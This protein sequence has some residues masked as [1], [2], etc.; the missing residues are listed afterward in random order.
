MD[1][2]KKMWR[3]D[4]GH[5]YKLTNNS[6]N[7]SDSFSPFKFANNCSLGEELHYKGTLIRFP[8][9]KEPSGLSDKLYTIPKLKELL[10]ALNDDAAILLL[11]L[12]YVERIEVFTIDAN[13]LVTKIFSVE[14]DK[15]SECQRRQLKLAFL[16]EVG[17][18]HS[19][20]SSPLPH[21]QYE[22]TITVHDVQVGTHCECQWII[23]HWVG[24][25]DKDVIKASSKVS[26]LPWIGLAVPLTLQCS[27]R[28]FCFLPLPD[29]KEVNPP[30]PLC[31]HGTFGLNKDRRHLK[32]IT[33][34][35]KNDDGAL[36]NK[37]LFSD[38]LPSCYAEC[39]NLLKEKCN[40]EI[41]YSFWPCVSVV[42]TTNWNIILHPLL[43]LLLQGQYFWSENGRWVGLDSSVCVVPQ[44][45]S[46]QFPKVVIDVLIK[47]GKTVVVLP[48][49]VWDAVK[50][51]NKSSYPFATITPSA[52][53]QTIRSISQSYSNL[54]KAEKFQLLH[55]CL[56]DKD[57][58]NLNGI[59]LLPTVVNTFIA[60]GTDQSAVKMYVCDK[61]FL[62]TKLLANNSSTLVNVEGEDVRLHDK[63]IEVANS[64][65]TQLHILKPE[66]VA[67][68]LKQTSPFQN[69]WCCYGSAGGF[70]NENWLKTFWSW[71]SADSLSFFV[72][73]PLI[74]VC[75]GKDDNGFKVVELNYQENTQ[76]F[77]C[78]QSASLFFC[79]LVTAGEKLGCHV[80]SSEE[81]AF[82]DCSKL[83][84]YVPQLSQS[85]LLNV[86]HANLENIFFSQEEATALRQFLFYH[87]INFSL[88]VGQRLVALKLNIFTIVQSN[89][90]TSLKNATNVL[91][92]N[93]S[94]VIVVLEPESIRKYL[95]FLPPIITCERNITE[96]LQPMLPETCWFPTKLQLIINVIF[97]AI[98]NKQLNKAGI[99]KV[100]SMLLEPNEYYSLVITSDGDLLFNKLKLLKYLPTSD[101]DNDNLFSPC[102]VYD[103]TDHVVKELFEGQNVFP[104]APF[105]SAHFPILKQLG[106]KDCNT[107]SSSD[108][109]RVTDIICCETDT[110]A[111]VKRANT[112]L[113]FLSSPTGN[114]LLNEY[115]NNVPLDQTLR[116][117]Q[118]LPVITTPPKGY[119]KCLSWKGSS[120][121]QFVF[122]QSLHASSSPEEHKKLPNLIGSQMKIL[123]YEGTLSVKLI[124]SLNIPQ[125]VPV[126][127]MILQLLDLIDHNTHI[128]NN[129]LKENVKQLYSYLQHAAQQNQ[130]SQYWLLLSQSEVVQ[131]SDNKFVLPSVVAC[132]FDQQSE[133]VGTLEPY[134]YILP[135]HLQQ[136]R[137]LFQYIGV[138]EQITVSDVLSVLETISSLPNDDNNYDEQ[139]S[140]ITKVLKWVCYSFTS[141]EIQ[142]LRGAIFVPVK[143]GDNQLILKPADQVACLDEDLQWL[144]DNK[145]AL[146][147]IMQDYFLVHPS[148]SYNMCC[149]L[150][151]KPLNTMIANSEEF[152]FEQAG[153]SEPL[154]TRLNRI[155]R[156]YKDTSVIQELLQ[157]AD[158]AGA[159]EVA[160]FYDTR[161]HDSSHLF[162]PGM[163]NSYGP[164]LLFYNNAE[165]SE[166]DFEN[167][168][169]IAGET[170]MNKP[171]KIGKFGVGF[172][173]VYHITDVPSFVS[174]ENFVVF[175]PTLQCLSKE[176]KS[177]SNPRIKI[178]FNKHFLL[179]KSK[180]LNPYAGI[181]GFNPCKNFEGT[182]FRFP[183]RSTSSEIS[184]NT[185]TESKV[186]SIIG[187]MK[188]YSSKLLM[189]LHNVKKISFYLATDDSITKNFEVTI[190]KQ[191]L[192]NN[193]SLLTI[194]TELAPNKGKGEN[195][196]W[197]VTTDTKSLQ[198]S[199]REKCHGTSSV[200]IKLLPSITP[201]QYH[202][203]DITGECFCFL[204]LNI[205]T[206]LPVHVSSNFAVTTNRRGIWKADNAVTAT[207]ESNW[208]KMLMETVVAEAY[209]KLLF[210]LQRMQQVGYIVDYNFHSLWPIGLREINPWEILVNKI[211]TAILSNQYSLF[212]SEITTQ[213]YKLHQCNFLSNKILAVGVGSNDTILQSSLYHVATV[214]HLPVVNLPNSLWSKFCVYPN[215]LSQVINEGK[216]IRH[217][218]RDQ[219]L[220][221][222]SAE[223]KTE[224]VTAS[225]ITYAKNTHDN[226]L[227]ELLKNTKCIPCSPDGKIFKKPL[228]LLDPTSRMGK[229][230]L[231]EDGMFPDLKFLQQNNILI[232]LLAKIGL[233]Q[234]LCW[235]IVIDRA[236]CVQSWYDTNSSEALGR[237]LVLI[238][239]IEENSK[240]KFLSHRITNELQSIPFLP[241]MQKPQHYPISWKGDS[242]VGHLLPGPKLT[243]V[244]EGYLS[245]NAVH[246]CGS[247]V[248]IL[249]TQF[250]SS[251]YHRR[252][253]NYKVQNILGIKSDIG[254]ID[255][256]NHFS[257]LL[258]WFQA[259][260]DDGI[261]EEVLKNVSTIVMSV[262]QYINS[263]LSFPDHE[264]RKHLIVLKDK[265]CIW[266]TDKFLIPSCVAINWK[267]DGPYLYKLPDGL[268]RFR[269]LVNYL[270]I[271]ANFATETYLNT[272]NKMKNDYK[273]GSLP[274]DCQTVIR[275][276][277]PQLQYA[278]VNANQHLSLPDEEFVLRS[279]ENLKYNDAP[280]CDPDEEYVYCH[281]C[282]ERTTAIRLGVEPMRSALLQDHE[283]DVEGEEFGQ[284]EDLT[285]RL[286]N[287]L[288]DYP[289][290]I[291]FLK[292]ILQNADD[293][294]A[295][296]LYITLDKRKHNHQKVI[297]EE[298]KELHGPALL[299]W[300]DS[301]F[302]K[303]DFLGIQKLG[304]GSKSIDASTVGQYGIGFNVV[305][306]FTDCPSFITAGKLCILDPYHY[307][308]A[309]DKRKRPGKIL[310]NL[311][312]LWQKFPDMKS[313]YLLNDLGDTPKE[314]KTKGSLFRLP[315]RQNIKHHMISKE[316]ILVKTLEKELKE[317]M[318]QVSEA[319]L[320]LHHISDVKFFIIDDN[321]STNDF[322]W[323]EATLFHHVQSTKGEQRVIKQ[324]QNGNAKLVSYPMTLNTKDHHVT[325]WIVQLGKGNVEDE[326][327]DWNS[328][329]PPNVACNPHHGIAAPV[330]T[331][332]FMGKS[333]CY[334][335]LPGMTRLPV[336]VHGH[337]I[338]HSD[339][340]GLWVSS[341]TKNT[342]SYGFFSMHTALPDLKALWNDFMIKAVGVSYAYLLLDIA[343]RMQSPISRSTLLKS[344]YN[345]YPLLTFLTT[346]PWSYLIKY[347][348]LTLSRLNAPILAKLTKCSSSKIE[349]SK[350]PKVDSDTEWFTVTWYKLLMPNSRNECYFND[351]NLPVV[352]VLISIGMN[353]VDTPMF[354]YKEFKKAD[355]KIQL[356]VVSRESVVNY[357]IQFCSQILN[358]NMLPCAISSTQFIDIK[359]ISVLLQYLMQYCTFSKE[360]ISDKRFVSLGLIVTV[361][362]NLHSLSDGKGIVS[363]NSWRSFPN[364]KQCFIHNDLRLCYP[365]QSPYL[366]TSNLKNSDHFRCI[367]SIIHDNYSFLSDEIDSTLIRNVLDCLA[368]DPVFSV[369]CNEILSLFALLPA[370]NNQF[371]STRSDILPLTRTSGTSYY[372]LGKVT[373]LMI[374]LNVPLLQHEVVG[375]IL[376]K[377]KLQLPSVNNPQ[378]ILKS[379]YLIRKE[380][381]NFVQ[382]T[383]QEL[384]VLFTVFKQIPYSN[385]DNQRYI[386]HLPVFTTVSSELVMLASAKMVW[387][388][389][390]KE[391]CTAGIDQWISYVPRN[392]LFLSPNAPWACIRH[393]AKSLQMC[394]INRYDVYCN[395][396]FPNFHSLEP[397]VQM[398]HLEFVKEEVYPNCKHVLMYGYLHTSNIQHKV[399]S[400]VSVLKDLRCIPDDC[401]HLRAIRNFYDHDNHMFKLFCSESSFL[402]T[403]FRAQDWHEFFEYFGLRMMPAVEEFVSYCKGLPR[404]GSVATIKNASLVLLRALLCSPTIGD[405][406]YKALKSNECTR[407]ISNIPIAVIEEVEDL[408]CIKAQRMGEQIVNDGQ[409]IMHL[410]KL[411]GST[412]V[413]NKHLL[414]TIR[415]L[416]NLPLDSD[417]QRLQD[418]GV[419]QSPS[420]EDVIANL[421][422]LSSTVFA[423]DS[424]FDKHD[425]GPM[426]DKSGLLPEVVVTMLK[427]IQTKLNKQQQ[428]P[429]AVCKKYDLTNTKFLPVKL[430]ATDSKNYVLVKP[431][432]VLY[433]KPTWQPYLKPVIDS[434][435][436]VQLYPYLHPLI[437]E[438]HEVINFLSYTGVRVSL[439]FSH[440]QFVLQMVQEKC[441]NSVVDENIRRVIVKATDEL[442]KLLQQCEKRS[443]AAQY[444]KPLYLLSQD[445]KLVECS[446][447]IVY[448]I[449]GHQQFP[450]PAGYAY[451]NPLRNDYQ[452]RS[453]LLSELLPK[454]LGLKSLKS[455]LEYDII[456]SA[457]AEEVFPNVSII[458]DILLSKEFMSG[459]ELL[460]R[461]Y[462]SDGKTPSSV[463]RIL[464]NFQHGLSI[465]H[466][467]KF[468]VRPKIKI[469]NEIITLNNTIS[470]QLYLLQKSTGPGQQWILSLKNANKIYPPVTFSDLA[471]EL[472]SRL[473]LKSISCFEVASNDG[474]D[475]VTFVSLLIQC[476]SIP[477]VVK[478]IRS[479]VPDS[480]NSV[481]YISPEVT[482]IPKLSD[483]IPERWHH[484]LDQNI[485]NLFRPEEWVGYETED[486]TVVYAQV[487]YEIDQETVAQVVNNFQ[488]MMQRRFIITTG[489]DD[490]LEA[491]VLE[492][493]KF[494]QESTKKFSV[495]HNTEVEIHDSSTKSK[496]TQ[497]VID[498]KVI[499]A[500]VKAAF[501]L[502]IEQR[503]KAIK[504]LYLQYHPDKNPDNPNATAQFQ[505]LKEEIKRAEKEHQGHNTH[506]TERRETYNDQQ[507]SPQYSTWFSQWNQTASSHNE[508]RSRD[509]GRTPERG[510]FT[511]SGM[512]IPMPRIDLEE[513]KIWIEQAG[514]DYAALSVLVTASYEK[515]SAAACF[516]CHEVA[517][518]SLKAGM[519]AK[520]GVGQVSL[521][522]HN[523]ALPAH[524]LVQLG[525]PIDVSDAHSL[526]RFYLDT[527]FPNRYNPSA[528]PGKKFNSAIAKQAFE[529][530]TRIFITM[531]EMICGTL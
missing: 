385:E 8:L 168:R 426:A 159:T 221:V 109:I 70:Y 97:F 193:C 134:W 90:L 422:G 470:D 322:S 32:W 522:N 45:N 516:M 10:K 48:E 518:K 509:T 282:V 110:Q 492:L 290:D 59:V 327:F 400:F 383:K 253:L 33:S 380:E 318:S 505:F 487:L 320:F 80:T 455:M 273:H 280:W 150:E 196:V 188:L 450:P 364:S 529:A 335:P 474:P 73:I 508:F 358:G 190:T 42:N 18:Y 261:D 302:S 363:S 427:C 81:F 245:V 457:Q 26:S 479:T 375:N 117:L 439:D 99:V 104:I 525:C 207:K 294:G 31:V 30:L 165:F 136:Y 141:E 510:A 143:S 394:S 405:D 520:C 381:N 105:S 60:F 244:S 462:S 3:G 91:K 23:M 428:S 156:E 62:D 368:N 365:A 484:R 521:N 421:K 113:K 303:E 202:V 344:Y 446:K 490:P 366:C 279:T 467:N 343:I 262:Y 463:T 84:G 336:H 345:Y 238:E 312:K 471:K 390:D 480:F 187:N 239:C 114:R 37:V 102:E 56:E 504:R 483:I 404:L 2:Q 6:P 35:M 357:Y 389:N 449:V 444:L 231:P 523:L 272:L 96:N 155:L 24:S 434:S 350:L 285:Q 98:E 158:D 511:F 61:Q 410:A 224:I 34:D 278:T 473:Q 333:F 172:C 74:P 382:L 376:D 212:Y 247:Q 519:Y 506:E 469:G 477:K 186:S 145:E 445:D 138:K 441:Q 100:T 123:Q 242:I 301:T 142:D 276:I 181:C 396:I 425:V 431:I 175:D 214:L 94:M 213:W 274:E 106:M 87:S 215:F 7:Y 241:V 387:I 384:S 478:V 11:F 313:S 488:K 331:E 115:Y 252:L 416:I 349:T 173:S 184:D 268:S 15:A 260:S 220:S 163:A 47:C 233:M 19:N 513:A 466:F 71:V 83:S 305:Y 101:D 126:D 58:S 476:Q 338:L 248:A 360:C 526:E 319:L 442:I 329:R 206:G 243:K 397:G 392:V 369:Y 355:D 107:L 524:A 415:P 528:V 314:I 131:V 311:E 283:D 489:N 77:I 55:Y 464:N 398:A 79:E 332:N 308:V 127:A 341:S 325:E 235:D 307:Y 92:E 362:G 185:F 323:S 346:N 517:E 216:F 461:S 379:L 402:P 9:R 210:Y 152:G 130:I 269:A 228:H 460:A 124:A 86:S 310:K 1:P 297:S 67:V 266:I 485:L 13:S 5:K 140:F 192:N 63:L 316:V 475:L 271:K 112:L 171:L 154:T 21:L 69:G 183:L 257:D 500:A 328:I 64:R 429:E 494:I 169:K 495:N 401:G 371:Y 132:S 264:L 435:H 179:K 182:L 339:R 417:S 284:W 176:I 265:P 309:H 481:M 418:C 497:H 514:Y 340:R 359:N 89:A 222:V 515:V 531:Q 373:A 452:I 413:D 251:Q 36:W 342:S 377:I 399:Q 451:L 437:K 191:N 103:P 118:W 419:V 468:R 12:R 234:T 255:V 139:N 432:Q 246:A 189:F 208:N 486:G 354:I 459:I 351:E 491:H 412:I 370:S 378:D 144:S 39:L 57:Y 275:L 116:S 411:S 436:I 38:I 44:V 178:N 456:D 166:E 258:T 125:S 209:L 149:T 337:F 361:D 93:K 95:L 54:S 433:I 423:N 29:S 160:L 502:P 430:L 153:Q 448:N 22:A 119:P 174:G 51:F 443:V 27:S 306:H 326:N 386:R 28:L 240:G 200:S 217:F 20:P 128:E 177:D 259:C 170:K 408:N 296:K 291:T 372:D 41:F 135:H 218:Y 121:S 438:A 16:S 146:G 465:K 254:S 395:Y 199:F 472:C 197:L 458:G 454:E 393:E 352:D 203:A 164:A 440:I 407:K 14:I 230:F 162:F 409:S 330:N 292:E 286:N 40:P 324:S 88:N 304:L 256:M 236:K 367:L 65:Y 391:V 315:L 17:K 4:P 72:N 403:K 120:G 249:D 46:S 75:F 52:V 507:S 76:V 356:S 111:K 226:V 293:A 204:P 223:A 227:P 232:T 420:L 49:N 43:S 300:N 347:L 270:G 237:L 453:K 53:R 334:L 225:L 496:Q 68:L 295:T 263:K 82:L 406:K 530:A 180:Q 85:L 299:F 414:W 287:I 250:L 353:I 148:I 298:W 388:W 211:Y 108:I 424:R 66:S 198:T 161:E 277:L 50:F 133:T 194:S 167:I 501:A 321:E 201:N 151:L 289:R 482:T 229:L 129:F 195:S 267:M 499:R 447:L 348:Y 25:R 512:N 205:E 527:R 498:C 137:P 493:Y 288:R 157:N 281:E 219:T 78:N 147:D 503:N 122:A 317:W 374:K